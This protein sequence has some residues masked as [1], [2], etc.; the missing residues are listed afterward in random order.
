MS[1]RPRL[2]QTPSKSPS[3]FKPFKPPLKKAVAS[4]KTRS[5]LRPD[6]ST[7]TSTS[8]KSPASSEASSLQYQYISLQNELKQTRSLLNIANQAVEL[9]SRDANAEADLETLIEQWR[10]ASR[11]AA[12]VVFESAKQR[13]EG[14]GRDER[15]DNDWKRWRRR[16]S[17]SEPRW[18]DEGEDMN[19]DGG[20]DEE[21]GGEED[22]V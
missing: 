9:V 15:R 2:S 6:T 4:D 8:T 1:R 19:H 18:G 5:P 3:V 12:E 10:Q 14:V 13:F 16:G 11:D 21:G 17:G 20:E 22:E 7:S